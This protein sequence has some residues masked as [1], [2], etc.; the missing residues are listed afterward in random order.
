MQWLIKSKFYA[1]NPILVG[2]T[3][4]NNFVT[5]VALYVKRV[6]IITILKS[7]ALFVILKFQVDLREKVMPSHLLKVNNIKMIK[8]AFQVFKILRMRNS[9][10]TNNFK[11]FHLPISLDLRI[12]NQPNKT[13]L[14][15]II[16]T[17]RNPWIQNL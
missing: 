7:N 8:N 9:L 1:A 13:F 11:S 15:L 17:L 5:K 16:K 6:E 2:N 10:L 12:M 3:M 14:H 4:L